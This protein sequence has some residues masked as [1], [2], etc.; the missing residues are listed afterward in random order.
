MAGAMGVKFLAQG[1]NSSRKVP[2][3]NRTRAPG[4]EPHDYQT[5]A[6]TTGLLLPPIPYAYGI[7]SIPY[8]YFAHTRMGYPICVYILVRDAHKYAYGMP[9]RIWDDI[10]T[11]VLSYYKRLNVAYNSSI[12]V[13]T[14][15]NQHNP[16]E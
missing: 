14:H 2:A 9:I 15:Q 6:Q 12:E 1:N 3:E 5:D 13:Q 7:C 8:A 10:F 4:L 11:E 16:S